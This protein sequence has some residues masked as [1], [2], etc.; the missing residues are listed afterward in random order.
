MSNVLAVFGATGQQGGSIV[1]YVLKYP[2]LSKRYK[3]RAI[4]RDTDS[5][6]AKQLSGLGKVD[7]VRGDVSDQG[8]LETA[9][10]GV[11]TIFA[12]TTN[13]FAPNGPELEYNDGKRIADVAVAKGVQYIIFSTLPF[14]KEISSGKYTSTTIFDAKAKIE[15]YIRGLPIK[16]AF[17]SPGCFL[18]NFE[19]QKWVTSAQA[20]QH[21]GT[22]VMAR[23]SSPNLP[24]PLI[25]VAEDTGKFVGA[26]LAEPEKFKGKTFCAAVGYYTLQEITAV[27]SKM[28][29][30][31]VVYE[32]ISVDEFKKRR[33]FA[34]DALAEAYTYAEEFGYWGRDSEKLVVWSVE[35]A[36]G[37][38]TTLEEFLEKHPLRLE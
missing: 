20:N 13:S 9:L 31:R 24:L 17:Y 37:K 18:Q 21:D 3:I 23:H 19:T 29:G 4:T 7:V 35:N 10:T 14:V 1:K 25:D 28:T 15:R 6:K 12:M 2:E 26:I 33:P 38:L 16:S 32:Q 22:W 36:R 5:E 27:I 11:H 34:A 30:K 8:S